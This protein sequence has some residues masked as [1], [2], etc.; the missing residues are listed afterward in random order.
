[1]RNL[2]ARQAFRP[3]RAIFAVSV[4]LLVAACQSGDQ[5][6]RLQSE[7]VGRTT[8]EFFEAYGPPDQV[9]AMKQEL[10]RDSTG[11]VLTSADPKEL[12]YYW[13]SINRKTYSKVAT[14]TSDGCNLAIL[15]TAEGK[16]LLIEAQDD[17][18]DAAAA[19]ARCEGVID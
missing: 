4:L 15:S 1:M 18:G 5:N 6:P 17:G 9:I 14:G 2:C 13:S 12:V 16:I 10:K 7:Y 3:S 8:A 19:K 11:R